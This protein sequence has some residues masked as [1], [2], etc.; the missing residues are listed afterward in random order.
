MMRRLSFLVSF[1]W[2]AH[3]AAFAS[4]TATLQ[5]TR[6]AS[7]FEGTW[8]GTVQRG[9]VG[10]GSRF[11]LTFVINADG[12]TVTF[13][14]QQGNSFTWE[15]SCDGKT[16]RWHGCAAGIDCDWTLT[17]NADGSTAVVT[18]ILPTGS[19]SGNFHKESTAPQK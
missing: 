9:L 1:A 11:D 15:A 2:T 10:F 6:T 13:K 3:G 18:D 17:P 4:S 8:T 12:T 14:T 7:V 16:V 5:P 19:F